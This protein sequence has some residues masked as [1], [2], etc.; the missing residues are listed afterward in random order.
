M[1]PI[2]VHMPPPNR[3]LAS[4]W[5]MG[6]PTKNIEV[7]V[8]QPFGWKRKQGDS[9]II[10]SVIEGKQAENVG[11]K[12]GWQIVAVDG[13]GVSSAAEF[14]SEIKEAKNSDKPKTVSITFTALQADFDPNAAKDDSG[15][16]SLEKSVSF[17]AGGSTREGNEEEEKEKEE[18]KGEGGSE[19]PGGQKMEG[20]GE[21]TVAEPDR[22]GDAG[23]NDGEEK[24]VGDGGEEKVEETKSEAKEE[25]EKAA[26][27]LEVAA[28]EGA[29]KEGGA[30]A[31]AE[32]TSLSL[33]T[34]DGEK[35]TLAGAADSDGDNDT[36]SKR[37]A[38]AEKMDLDLEAGSDDE[39]PAALAEGGVADADKPE[40]RRKSSVTTMTPLPG[41]K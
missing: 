41:A 17:G 9:L 16:G 36:P 14:D 24:G 22:K 21:T 25:E 5:N 13:V 8:S 23:K 10:T 31:A 12:V 1:P 7:D 4:H 6:P 39:A 19:E 3:L 27:G 26:G 30:A 35:G 32:D 38:L 29:S 28:D 11:I 40:R 2:P 15:K 20:G 33:E 34:G 37:A 18:E